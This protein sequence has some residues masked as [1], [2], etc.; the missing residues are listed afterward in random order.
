M[1]STT[2]E[3]KEVE[4]PAAKSPI[5]TKYT[6]KDLLPSQLQRKIS[7]DNVIT[8]T[9]C[10]S[11]SIPQFDFE[12]NDHQIAR[13]GCIDDRDENEQLRIR[14]L[15]IPQFNFDSGNHQR[16][17]I[18]CTGN[19][20]EN[21]EHRIRSRYQGAQKRKKPIFFKKDSKS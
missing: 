4:S 16:V 10:A 5:V 3:K 21:E 12:S 19:R 9:K 13:I 7:D 20:I 6:E 2:L 8:L 11:L 18:R 17:P 15:T 1:N 14:S